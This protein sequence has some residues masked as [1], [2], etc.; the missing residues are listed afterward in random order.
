MDIFKI[1][2]RQKNNNPYHSELIIRAKEEN[3]KR[4]NRNF[5]YFSKCGTI[6]KINPKQKKHP[7]INLFT[8]SINV[9]GTGNQIRNPY[10]I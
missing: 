8:K 4:M 3:P 7:Q 6:E 1:K 10:F 5:L 9:S 2:T